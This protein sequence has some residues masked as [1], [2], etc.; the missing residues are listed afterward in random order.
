MVDRTQTADFSVTPT[1]P[2]DQT[3]LLQIVVEAKKLSIVRDEVLAKIRA[4]QLEIQDD[5]DDYRKIV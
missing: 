1:E 3:L 5:I 4:E 2:Q